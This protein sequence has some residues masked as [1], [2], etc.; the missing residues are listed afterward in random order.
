MA[1]NKSVVIAFRARDHGKSESRSTRSLRAEQG[2]VSRGVGWLQSSLA[3]YSNRR[4]L[5]T[6]TII[7]CLLT[8]SLA[9]YSNRRWLHTQIS[10]LAAYSDHGIQT[11]IRL[12]SALHENT[13][14]AACLYTKNKIL[15]NTASDW[16]FVKVVILLTVTDCYN[17]RVRSLGR[18]SVTVVRSL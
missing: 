14:R 16:F 13:T 17:S 10:S 8:S 9:A 11:E 5:L 4:W 15:P 12:L 2:L 1:K 6:H 7:G 3:A 18:S